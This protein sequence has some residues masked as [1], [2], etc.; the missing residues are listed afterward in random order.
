[1]RRNQ[2]VRHR[3]CRIAIILINKFQTNLL[4]TRSGNYDELDIATFATEIIA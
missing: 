3:N 4:L 2:T 1:M